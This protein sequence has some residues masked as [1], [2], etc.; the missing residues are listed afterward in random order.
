MEQERR[1][2]RHQEREQ[3]RDGRHDSSAVSKRLFYHMKRKVFPLDV[4]S[5]ML[6][7]SYVK[8][9]SLLSFLSNYI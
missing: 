4:R 3:R 9:L 5:C 6:M 7:L 2:K 1:E 8:F